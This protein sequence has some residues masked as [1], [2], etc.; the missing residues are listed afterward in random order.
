[1]AG[2][3]LM[4][5]RDAAVIVAGPAADGL[6]RRVSSAISQAAEAC[7]RAR[8]LRCQAEWVQAETIALHQR[9][10]D[11]EPGWQPSRTR[12][13]LLQQSA[14]ARLVARLETMPVIEQAKGIIMAQSCCGEAEAFDVLRRASQRSNVPVRELAAQI[15]AKVTQT[16]DPGQRPG[17]TPGRDRARLHRAS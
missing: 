13:E 4:A 16:A 6:G 14:C 10:G 2:G 8:E 15:V 3:A 11:A 9:I 7:S 5:D 1:M 17:R 12:Q